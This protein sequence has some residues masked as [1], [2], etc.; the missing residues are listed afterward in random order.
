MQA[1]SANI[2]RQERKVQKEVFKEVRSTHCKKRIHV[3]IMIS[4]ICHI[5]DPGGCVTFEFFHDDVWSE[6]SNAAPRQTACIADDREEA[7]VD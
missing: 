4:I 5:L 3:Y 2:G 6:Y 7:A 1:A